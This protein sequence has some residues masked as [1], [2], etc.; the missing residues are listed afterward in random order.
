MRK[1]GEWGEFFPMQHCSYGYNE[2]IAQEFFPLKKEEVL[3]RKCTWYEAD[4]KEYKPQTF[5]IP[6]TIKDVPESVCQELLVCISCKKNYKIIPQE[7]AFYQK[8]TLPIPRKCAACRHAER[9]RTR[10]PY[11]L[12]VRDCAKCKKSMK[13]AF[14]PD[15]PEI[16][17]CEECYLK[18]VY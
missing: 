7:L 4:A 11:K 18:E 5:S 15:R 9:G 3:A 6:D 8:M 10:T 17:E 13:T 1:A 12:W 14:A 2:T 16:V